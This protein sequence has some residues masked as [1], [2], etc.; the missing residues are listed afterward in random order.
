MN[1]HKKGAHR[2]SPT[3]KTLAKERAAARDAGM[4]YSLG[5][6]IA[7]IGYVHA[8]RPGKRADA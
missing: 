6:V 3:I 2:A 4:D 1:A 7:E 5:V 8:A